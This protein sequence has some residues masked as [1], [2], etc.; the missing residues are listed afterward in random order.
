MSLPQKYVLRLAVKAETVGAS[1]TNSGRLFHRLGA[2][3]AKAQSPLCFS[4]AL[5]TARSMQSADLRDLDGTCDVLGHA[6]C[7]YNR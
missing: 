6:Y 5:G 1:L 2:A 3:T 7:K 4:L